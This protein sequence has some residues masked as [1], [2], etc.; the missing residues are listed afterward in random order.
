MKFTTRALYISIFTSLTAFSAVLYTSC[1]KTPSG[2]DNDCQ[3]IA[4]AHGG[5]CT[6]GKCVC[7][8]GYE[9]NNCEITTR[10]RYLGGWKVAE[11]GTTTPAREYQVAIETSNI[12]AYHVTL[13]NVYNYFKAPISAYVIKDT[14]FIPN[15]QLEGKV[16]FG[17]G[18]IHTTNINATENNTLTMLYEVIDSATQV[19]DDFGY[20]SD[21]DGSTPSEWTR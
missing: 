17:R 14:I 6:N 11:K 13:K 10:A 7:P 2:N 4:C 8:S 9:G 12:D 16:I 15:Q 21:L 18:Y 20:Y 5:N 3:A 1:G 19:V